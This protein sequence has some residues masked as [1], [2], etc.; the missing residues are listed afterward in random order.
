M[1]KYID[2]IVNSIRRNPND[3][4][5]YGALGLK[6]G[7]TTLEDTGNGSIWFFFWITSISNIKINGEDL[8][9]TL[10]WIDH[11]KLEMAFKWWHRNMNWD[12]IKRT[13]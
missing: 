11:I 13:K 9:L 5:R 4:V 3:W 8:P 12:H 10:S 2:E 1:S 6:K 7:E